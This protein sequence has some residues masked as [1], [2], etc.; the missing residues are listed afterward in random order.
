MKGHTR[1][2]PS[3]VYRKQNQAWQS[4]QVQTTI[5]NRAIQ[6]PR[7]TA[8][9][10][11][12]NFVADTSNNA[13]QPLHGEELA[14]LTAIYH[15]MGGPDWQIKD[16]WMS[17]SN[18]CGGGTTN[19]TWYGVKCVM[20]NVSLGVVPRVNSTSYVTGLVLPQNNLVGKLPPLRGLQNLLHLDLSNAGSAD[21]SAGLINS[22]GGTLDALC[23]LNNLS[24]VLLTYN[25]I[26]GSIPDC[27][28]ILMFC[29]TT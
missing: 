28:S 24:T 13:P 3:A 1:A 6:P 2:A 15:G 7:R 16:G 25:S 22:V 8:T 14:T 19:K 12:Y 18:P 10:P 17:D 9:N 4:A 20:L 11:S 29:I 26:T 23:G 5:L 27:I 21:T